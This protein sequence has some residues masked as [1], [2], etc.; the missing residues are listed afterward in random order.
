MRQ[1]SSLASYLC[2]LV[3]LDKSDIPGLHYPRAQTQH[4]VYS[5]MK[6]SITN[7]SN[8]LLALFSCFKCIFFPMTSVTHMFVDALI[9]GVG[10]RLQEQL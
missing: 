7:L 8:D 10:K 5:K 6:Y 4:T 3:L 2:P 1:F 9:E